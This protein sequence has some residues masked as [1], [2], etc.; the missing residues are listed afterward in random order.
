MPAAV[1]SALRVSAAS[2]LWTLATSAAAI[3]LGLADGSLA[4]VAFG[5]VQVFD[6]AASVVLI[7]H[8]RGGAGVARLERVVLRVVAAGLVAVGLVTVVVSGLHLLDH[9]ASGDAAGGV[10]LA[11][12]AFAILTVLAIRKRQLATRLPSQALRADGNLTSVGAALAA[13]T[14]VGTAAA[15]GFGWW[16]ADPVAALI[17]A[18][19][20]LG[21]GA[22]TNRLNGA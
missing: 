15:N 8:F 17:I 13:V 7:V 16:W 9:A 11:A 14:V 18:I 1:R 2:A 12:A 5:A 10:P 20:A 21:V 22:T 19:G 6:F 3:A 4:L